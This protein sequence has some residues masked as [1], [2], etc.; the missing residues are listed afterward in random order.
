MAFRRFTAIRGFPN[1]VNS[2][3]GNQLVGASIELKNV[4]KA[5]DWERF[6]AF[7][8]NKNLEWVFSLGDSPWYNGCCES[9]I[10]SIK[11]SIHHAIGQ[12]RVSYSELHTVI[13]EISDIINERPIGKKPNQSEEG[14]YLCPND[15][16]LGRCSGK[17]PLQE[18]DQ[19]VSTRKRYLFTQQSVDV[20]WKKWITYYFPSLIIQ[21]KWHHDKR[22]TMIGDVVLIQDSYNLRGQWKLG[23]NITDISW[24]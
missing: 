14:S 4:F 7:G 13:F 11:K 1:K 5:L 3:G 19:N 9:L 24:N 21:S 10:K 23:K 16:L 17:I 18:F 12:H 2:D 15:M 22:N 20:Y 8:V 6:K